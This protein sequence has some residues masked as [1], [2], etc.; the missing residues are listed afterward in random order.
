MLGRFVARVSAVGR[1]SSVGLA[2]FT[3]SVHSVSRTPRT[4]NKTGQTFLKTSC[5]FCGVTRK[6]E[7]RNAHRNCQK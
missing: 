3:Y 6:Y 7:F 1:L 5:H 2:R 4:I